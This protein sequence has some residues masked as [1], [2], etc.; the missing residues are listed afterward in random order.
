MSFMIIWFTLLNDFQLLGKFNFIFPRVVE[1]IPLGLLSSN[2][3]PFLIM[4]QCPW[5]ATSSGWSRCVEY[6][7]VFFSTTRCIVKSNQP[8]NDLVSNQTLLNQ[9]IR[10]Y[11]AVIINNIPKGHGTCGIS[12]TSKL[13]AVKIWVPFWIFGLFSVPKFG[14]YNDSNCVFYVVGIQS[15]VRLK[16]SKKKHLLRNYLPVYVGNFCSKKFLSGE[17]ILT[18]SSKM[19]WKL[20][21]TSTMS[22]TKWFLLI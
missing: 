15:L 21:T 17:I 22:F 19:Q 9:S 20:L 5:N 6:M 10:V 18:S 8:A 4:L 3:A 14:C 13:C 16:G 12:N 1:N 2:I 11:N 7:G